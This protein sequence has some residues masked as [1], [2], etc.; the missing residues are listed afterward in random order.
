MIVGPDG[1]GSRMSP[2]HEFPHPL[3]G[4]GHSWQ[5]SW[6]LAGPWTRCSLVTVG[7]MTDRRLPHAFAMP[8][9]MHAKTRG[10]SDSCI[11]GSGGSIR[12]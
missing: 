2:L 11:T 4:F 5:R 8:R 9:S 12:T 3:R 6:A 1:A 10:Q 7:S